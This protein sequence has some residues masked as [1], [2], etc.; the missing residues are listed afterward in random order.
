MCRGNILLDGA[1]GECQECH[2]SGNWKICDLGE[3]KVLR[4]PMLRFS[5]PAKWPKGWSQSLIDTG[6]F[7][8][9]TSPFLLERGAQFYCW[10]NPGETLSPEPGSE[11]PPHQHSPACE[12]DH[13]H[14]DRWVPCEHGAFVYLF[15]KSLDGSIPKSDEQDCF[16]AVSPV[17]D[18]IDQSRG[19]RTEF[20]QRLGPFRLSS[21][22]INPDVDFSALSYRVETHGHQ[23]EQLALLEKCGAVLQGRISKPHR[24]TLSLAAKRAAMIPPEA[25]HFSWAYQ[26]CDIR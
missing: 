11:S 16:F 22:A 25:T 15:G 2:H 19:L 6:R 8:R 3:A 13:V 23:S 24:I 9:V 4:A 21:A 26:G 20:P 17:N 5:A 12:Q 1:A 10:I 7:Q 18:E 14:K